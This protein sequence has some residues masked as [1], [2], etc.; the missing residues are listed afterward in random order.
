MRQVAKISQK[1]YRFFTDSFTGGEGV[2]GF[3]WIRLDWVGLAWTAKTLKV[4]SLEREKFAAGKRGHDL[5]K[6]F[7]Q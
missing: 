4:N 3:G 2:V 1:L 7:M 6:V 5:G